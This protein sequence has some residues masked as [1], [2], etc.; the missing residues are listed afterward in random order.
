MGDTERN[1]VKS[2][3]PPTEEHLYRKSIFMAMNTEI[4]PLALLPHQ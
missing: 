2:F 4:L 3:W 1:L